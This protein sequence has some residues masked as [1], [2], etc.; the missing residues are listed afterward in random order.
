MNDYFFVRCDC[1][2][3]VRITKVSI[4]N[5]VLFE[6]E[7]PIYCFGYQCPNCGGA[8]ELDGYDSSLIPEPIKS[9]ALAEHKQ[10]QLKESEKEQPR[11]KKRT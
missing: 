7:E 5:A 4:Y 1:G 8:V 3:D 6:P 10:M 2:T 11:N 9:A